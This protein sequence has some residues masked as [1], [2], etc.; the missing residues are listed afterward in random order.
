MYRERTDC[1]QGTTENLPIRV[2]VVDDSDALAAETQT[3]IKICV[4]D[5][6]GSHVVP[7]LA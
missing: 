3:D 2:H 7:T 5:R 6:P 4:P 1:N